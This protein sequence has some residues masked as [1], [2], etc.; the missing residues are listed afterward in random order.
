MLAK[1]IMLPIAASAVIIASYV[2]SL[3]AMGDN[4][5]DIIKTSVSQNFRPRGGK[6]VEALVLHCVGLSD[7]WVLKN[8]VLPSDQGGLGVSA[9]YYIPQCGS[10]YQLVPETKSA[11][12]AG[13][14]EWRNLAQENGLKGLNDLSIGI[15]FQSLGYAQLSKEGYFPYCFT[16]F[17]ETQIG[18]GISL[19]QQIMKVHG[20]T[21]EN[22]VWH[23]DISSRKTDPGPYFPVETFAKAGIGVWP[24]PDRL[25]DTQLDT[26]IKTLQGLLM[27]WG[28]PLMMQT[29]D[30]DEATRFALQAHYMHYLPNFFKWED[31]REKTSG[32]IFDELKNW[33]DFPYDK[34]TLFIS[35][36]NL[37]KGHYKY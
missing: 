37:N 24:S 5:L 25:E 32:S 19:S 3:I 18:L 22:V 20:I 11:F 9:H 12:H 34:D 28:Y 26:S 1:K 30:F 31:Y 10:I 8:Y 13:V 33:S 36:E 4:E 15:E 6:K 27:T 7:D 2:P 35:L 21:R 29:G 14:S 17:Q 16:P 23:S